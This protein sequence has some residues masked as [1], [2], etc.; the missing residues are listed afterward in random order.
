MIE[1][2]LT[3]KTNTAKDAHIAKIL[4]GILGILYINITIKNKFLL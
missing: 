2:S 3:N 1:Q 4:T